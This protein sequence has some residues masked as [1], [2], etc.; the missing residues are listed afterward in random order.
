M[1]QLLTQPLREAF[2]RTL[3]GGKAQM[4]GHLVRVLPDESV[5]GWVVT[6]TCLQTFLTA[7]GIAS[8]LLEMARRS[9][10]AAIDTVTTAITD[11]IW[12]AQLI[13]HLRCEYDSTTKPLCVRSSAVGEDG[14]N[15]SFAGIFRS[16]VNVRSFGEFLAAVRDCWASMFAAP[17]LSYAGHLGI[18]VPLMAVIVQPMIDS[19]GAG[20]AF[21]QD[22]QLHLSA[23]FGLGEGVV[24]GKVPCDTMMWPSVKADPV[25]TIKNKYSC[26]LANLGEGPL[27]PGSVAARPWLQNQR[28][29][30]RV[31]ATD[32]RH[33]VLRCWVL[34]EN[35]LSEQ[36]VLD[37]PTR[38]RLADLLY[39]VTD[40]IL[41][42]GDWDLEWCMDRGAHFYVVQ[43][44][45]ITSKLVP[46]SPKQHNIVDTHFVG[47]PLS[48]G[49]GVGPVHIL[50]DEDDGLMVKEGAVLYTDWIPDTFMSVLTKVS[51]L[52]VGDPSPLSHCA[53]VAREWQIP[54]V[55][56]VPGGILSIGRRYSID[57]STG[58]I[59]QVASDAPLPER[60][61]AQAHAESAFG[62]SL[63]LT[64]WLFTAAHDVYARPMHCESNLRTLRRSIEALQAPAWIDCR[65]VA[66]AL[67]SA[68]PPLRDTLRFVGGQALRIVAESQ[69]EVLLVGTD[70]DSR[71][72]RELAP[73]FDARLAARWRFDRPSLTL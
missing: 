5:D 31:S 45:P 49:I 12:P 28:M 42:G 58:H 22:G 41:G 1:T 27:W 14:T 4:L 61:P 7:S 72:G 63:M 23:A 65:G 55:G 26:Y 37:T 3:I 62:N 11:A 40:S 19:I 29:W 15:A 68:T 44:R 33:A 21:I 73:L 64:S 53:I 71:L 48:A 38:A 10:T 46:T 16:S 69:P 52:V 57:G 24:A 2:D 36:P 8:D 18:P 47:Q 59:C 20:V 43:A 25:V 51:A 17:A 13:T 50:T 32:R 35:E 30:F 34:P 54:C 39:R 67:A 9:D 66:T 70:E 56:G 60:L 6:T